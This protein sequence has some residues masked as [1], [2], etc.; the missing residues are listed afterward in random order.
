MYIRN[1]LH[2]G[3]KDK[4]YLE[5]VEGID[6]SHDTAYHEYKHMTDIFKDIILI[7]VG[8]KTEAFDHLDG[9]IALG[10][11]YRLE[12]IYPAADF[13]ISSSAFGE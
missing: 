7:L 12:K 11:N 6:V 2:N 10:E 3:G 5:R 1:Y 4:Y 8:N 9:V 13:I